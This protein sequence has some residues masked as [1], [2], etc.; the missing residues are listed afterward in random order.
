MGNSTPD[1]ALVEGQMYSENAIASGFSITEAS[2]SVELSVDPP[3]FEVSWVIFQY[4]RP[5]Q[6]YSQGKLF[7]RISII[8]VHLHE[9]ISHRIAFILF[10]IIWNIL[11]HNLVPIPFDYPSGPL[12]G[13]PIRFV[14]HSYIYMYSH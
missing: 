4:V 6:W 10:L 13:Y 12:G 9:R 8:G 5:L 3:S 1:K 14:D 11:W 2:D 7:R